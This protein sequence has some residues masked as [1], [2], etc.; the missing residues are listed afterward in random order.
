MLMIKM[1]LNGYTWLLRMFIAVMI[2][3][4][5]L[6]PALVAPG[7]AQGAAGVSLREFSIVDSNLIRLGDVFD[8]LTQGADKVLGAAPRPGTDMVLNARTLLRIAM[9]T[10]L[11]WRPGSST[12]TVTLRRA[13]TVIDRSEI[14]NTLREG[15]AHEGYTGKFILTIPNEQ[16]QIVLPH[17]QPAK[18]EIQS[19][20]VEKNRNTFEAVLA[21]PSNENP[22]KLL[23]VSGTIQRLVD[24]PV[25]R[26]PL[27]NGTVIGKND[28]EII[29]VREQDLQHDTVLKP[30]N[31]IG[32]T[33][34]RLLTAGETINAG[35]IEQPRIVARGENVVLIF[36]NGPLQLTAQG[37]ALEHGAIGDIIRVMNTSSNKT[38][39]GTVTASKEITVQTF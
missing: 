1:I 37:K 17:D 13:A 7:R 3:S 27:R 38:I 18:A 11:N 14:T 36:A 12:D 8:G 24:V 31:L 23:H 32:T 2:A 19:L 35:D 10:D 5:V 26:E 16:S 29:E 4:V 9:A 33:P 28:I 15:L 20:R 34:R 21:A 6:F 39:E 30:E 22:I 25:L